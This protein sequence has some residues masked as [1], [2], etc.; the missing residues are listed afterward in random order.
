VPKT[1]ILALLEFSKIKLN[2]QKQ[3]FTS[4]VQVFCIDNSFS[5]FLYTNYCMQDNK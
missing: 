4:E 1:R 2:H 3:F 5:I